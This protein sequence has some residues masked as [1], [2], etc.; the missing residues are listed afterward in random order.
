MFYLVD[1]ASFDSEV[2]LLR[3][4]HDNSL[5]AGDLSEVELGHGFHD[6]LLSA[7]ALSLA[8]LLNWGIGFGLGDLLNDGLGGRHRG[9]FSF[10]HDGNVLKSG[11]GFS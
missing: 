9:G 1:F 3:V 4:S 6:L 5:D 8:L 10:G 11:L 7:R 2:T